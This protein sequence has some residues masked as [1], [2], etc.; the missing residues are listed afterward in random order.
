[1][2]TKVT[3]NLHPQAGDRRPSPGVAGGGIIAPKQGPRGGDRLAKLER[4]QGM[5]PTKEGIHTG[6]GRQVQRL[7]RVQ[8]GIRMD[9]SE[10][11]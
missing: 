2:I 4:P 8:L 5:E 11:C 10:I 6:R 9:K 7:V 3:V 1:M